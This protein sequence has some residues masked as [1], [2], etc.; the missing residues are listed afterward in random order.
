MTHSSSSS[1]VLDRFS[2]DDAIVR[3][4][5]FASMLW[6]VVGM[7]VGVIAAIQL[8]L[9]SAN[10]HEWLSFGRLRP[11]HTNAVIFAFAGNAIF[12]AVYY[13]AQ[14]LLKARM[15]SDVLGRIHFWG[16]QL[17][18]VAAAVSLPLGF[19]QGKEYA[20]L[21]WPIDIAV[22]LIWVVFAVNLFGTIAVRRER[23]LYVAV[24]FYVATVV[25]IAVLYIF[26][27]LAMP[28][29][30]TKSYS[31]YAG[32]QDA[33]MQWWYGHNAVAF[34]LTTPFLG[35]M[36]YFLPKAA[37]RPVFS[38]RLSIVHFWSLVFLYIWAGPHHL[39]Y[40]SIPDWASTLG[41]LFSVMLWM[42]SWGGM[43]NGLLTLR[44]AWG[45]VTT[46]PVLKFFVLAITFYG[47]STF[48]GPLLSVKSVNALSHYT[49]WTI[50]HVHAGTL[51]WV[52]FMIFGMVYWLA[53]RLFQAPIARPSW[54]TLH[55]WLATIGIVLYIIPI[56][57]AGLMQGLNW[58]AFNSDGVLQYDF[59]TTVTKMVPLYWI[60]TV[61]GTLYLVAAIIGCI[62]LLMTWANRP[63]IYDVPVYEAAPLS[64]GWRPPTV[65][66]STLP[67]GSVTD[68][69]RAVDRFADLRWHRNLEGLPLA[70]SVCVAVAI[71]V[72][73]LFEVVP[74][75]AIRSDIPRIASVTPLTPLETIGRD[76]YVSEGCVNCHSQMI[77]PLIA[78]TERYGEYSKPGES[79]FDHP[80]LW[81]SRRIG[82]DLAREGVRNPSA[83]WHMRHFNRPVDTSPGSIMPAFAHLL[84]QPLDFTAAQP[85]MTA[86]QKV[87]VPYTAA[88]LVG[89]ADSARAQASR[90]ETQLISENGRSDGM[91]GM[92]ERR[93]IA[94][95]AYM[96]RLGTDLGKPIDVAPAPSAAAPIAMGAAQ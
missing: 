63:R 79:V 6:G 33:F 68:I 75:F 3:K 49:D 74:M 59:L 13:S 45:K 30:W 64:R 9:P 71:V 8:T 53:P 27:N 43:I 56:Y 32:S 25:A 77:R 70:F 5:V 54:V 1:A 65:P 17:I 18:I 81:G 40:T 55:F 22:V 96:Q 92:G 35:L 67:K 88:E 41:M 85:A 4:F 76:I 2:Y 52:G 69:G 34:F 28:S 21:E 16:W 10:V 89:A 26:N 39:H 44:G 61:G 82:P 84:D 15:F 66:Q 60:R 78:E 94:L 24:W 93:V 57:A 12:A 91:Q 47:M 31:I 29:G 58:R 90:I 62:N 7:L 38:Y 95:I 20:E 86:L 80:F 48:E 36:Y 72:A 83:L 46:D 50:A 87:G 14:R 23:H 42:P 37:D 11:L 73:T 51:G 19:T